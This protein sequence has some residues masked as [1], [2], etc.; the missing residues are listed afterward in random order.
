M[1]NCDSKK[2]LKKFK[3]QISPKPC[4]MLKNN[5]FE[6]FWDKRASVNRFPHTFMK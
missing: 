5:C 4:V 2:T 1:I 3:K 6:L